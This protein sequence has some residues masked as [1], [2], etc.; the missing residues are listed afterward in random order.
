MFANPGDSLVKENFCHR[1]FPLETVPKLSM[2]EN[3]FFNLREMK[4]FNNA[5]ENG[6]FTTI[7][8]EKEKILIAILDHREEK[9]TLQATSE[10][11]LLNKEKILTPI[12]DHKEENSTMQGASEGLS[13]KKESHKVQP[14]CENQNSSRVPARKCVRFVGTGANN[15][16][17]KKCPKQQIALKNWKKDFDSVF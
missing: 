13:L 11:L 8:G 2:V 9:S 5:V 16:P 12:L 3:P 14:N 15:P 4:N 6:A 1:T 7:L 17:E 10:G